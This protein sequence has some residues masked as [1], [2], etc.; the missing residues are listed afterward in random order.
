[1]DTSL[2][3]S[4][5]LSSQEYM[6]VFSRQFLIACSHWFL[7]SQPLD[8]KFPEAQFIKQTT[9][10]NLES[11]PRHKWVFLSFQCL[12]LPNFLCPSSRIPQSSSSSPQSPSSQ[13][14]SSTTS[15]RGS[16]VASGSPRGFKKM[17]LSHQ[18]LR[19]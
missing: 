19:P 3:G 15:L 11:F 5:V 8:C 12:S 6:R 4:S 14:L 16:P 9:L 13:S 2:H 18:F 1:M 10:Q 7:W 17:H